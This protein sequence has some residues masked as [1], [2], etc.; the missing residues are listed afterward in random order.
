MGEYATK[1]TDE[2]GKTKWQATDGKTYSTRSGAWK[3]SKRLEKEQGD[4]TNLEPDEATK[5]EAEAIHESPP[6]SEPETSGGEWTSFDFVGD[7]SDY[8]TEVV[9]S[10]LK[11]IKPSSG[12]TKK[13]K[14]QIEAETQTSIAMLGVGY[15][16]AAHLLTRYKRAVLQDKEAE[17]VTHSDEDID[18]ISGIT[19]DALLHSVIHIA[20]MMS[21]V[22]IAIV[23]N[24][25][26]FGKPL[27]VIQ[28][29]AK[30]SPFKGAMSG[31]G[32][33]IELIPFVG[34]RLRARRLA[35]EEAAVS[36][37]EVVQA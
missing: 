13:T 15:R 20:D 11:R 27:Y 4:S 26:W 6:S 34:S 17:P 37:G 7:E 2:E 19:N 23:A 35:A 21:P 33:F 10:V 1:T 31:V 8:P 25:Y 3:W 9:P 14:K 24:G 29:Q 22:Q 28:T 12:A 18:W 16:S 32:R 30:T 5:G 36:V